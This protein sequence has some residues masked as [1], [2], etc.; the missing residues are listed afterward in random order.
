[1]R[2]FLRK[3]FLLV[4]IFSLF[5]SPVLA[6]DTIKM[7]ADMN[8]SFDFHLQE[9]PDEISFVAVKAQTIPNI[10]T[11]PEDSTVTLEVINAEKERRWHKSGFI[12]GRLKTYCP[13]GV[14]IPVDVYDKGIYLVVRKYEEINPKEAVFFTLEYIVMSGASFFVPG[15]DIGYY[16]L[17][18]LIMGENDP[19]RFKSGVHNAYNNSICWLWLK[20]KSIEL[21]PDELISVKSINEVKAL[22]LS[23]KVDK[24]NLKRNIKSNNKIQKC[25][26]K[27]YKRQYKN[28][29]KDVQYSVVE[30]AINAEISDL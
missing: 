25:E 21:V 27:Y 5:L 23:S 11:I 19:N 20:G 28:A 7:L 17:K 15:V 26:D 10:V 22:K 24:R 14:E 9:I 8:S 2:S 1:M 18:G 4:I 16:F 3:I 12:I 30:R 6:K 13:K 29:K